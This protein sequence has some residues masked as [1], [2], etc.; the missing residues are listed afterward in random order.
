[1]DNKLSFKDHIQGETKSEFGVL[2]SLD[3][4][5][6]GHRGGSQSVYSRLYRSL[7]LPVVENGDPV[8]VS[9]AT[10]GCKEFREIQRSAML[11]ATGCLRSMNTEALEILTNTVPIDF[12]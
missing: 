12:S 2:R 8:W 6:H 10:E 7:V 3:T 5:V 11:K 9:A 4:F 1:M